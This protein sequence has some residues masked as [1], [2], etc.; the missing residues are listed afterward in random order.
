MALIWFGTRYWTASARPIDAAAI[1]TLDRTPTGVFG[2]NPF[3]MN[4]VKVLR[5]VSSR[6]VSRDSTLQRSKNHIGRLLPSGATPPPG[7]TAGFNPR[8][9]TRGPEYPA[10]L[11]A[12]GSSVVESGGNL[13]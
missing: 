12:S 5:A 1:G 3:R 10:G 9:K 11:R 2:V 4:W 6:W 13:E 8:T 7:L